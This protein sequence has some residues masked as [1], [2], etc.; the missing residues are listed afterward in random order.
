MSDKPIFAVGKQFHLSRKDFAYN[1]PKFH[2]FGYVSYNGH[3]ALSYTL[4]H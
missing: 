2:T 3:L 4:I 1:I